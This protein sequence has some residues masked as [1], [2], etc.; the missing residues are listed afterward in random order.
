MI[1]SLRQEIFGENYSFRCIFI[2]FA[3]K[4]HF[5]DGYKRE[6]TRDSS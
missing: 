5:I 4:S 3:D 1:N 6:Y 2:I